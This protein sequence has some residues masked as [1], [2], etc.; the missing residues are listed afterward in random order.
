MF[1]Q[2][3]RLNFG[4]SEKRF[5]IFHRIVSLVG[6]VFCHDKWSFKQ[7]HCSSYRFVFRYFYDI[8]YFM[9]FF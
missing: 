8:E 1:P 2:V 9:V 5:S 3:S 4:L 6:G 7:L